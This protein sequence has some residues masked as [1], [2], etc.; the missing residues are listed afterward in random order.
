MERNT[1]FD[2]LVNSVKD[3]EI[4]FKELELELE[5]AKISILLALI[6]SVVLTYTVT[7]IRN[8]KAIK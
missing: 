5:I 7:L 4:A 3:S 6:I 2:D 8:K 1:F